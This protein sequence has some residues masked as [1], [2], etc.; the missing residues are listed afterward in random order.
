MSKRRVGVIRRRCIKK[1]SAEKG[2][3][4]KLPIGKIETKE[5]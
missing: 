5:K 2:H 4:K 3:V 1:L